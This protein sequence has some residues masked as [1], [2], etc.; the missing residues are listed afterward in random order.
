MNAAQRATGMNPL[1]A[2][3]VATATVIGGVVVSQKLAAAAGVILF[4][5]GIG[6]LASRRPAITEPFVATSAARLRDAVT[7]QEPRSQGEV[8]IDPASASTPSS[9][10]S[11]AG[12][13][14]STARF[15]FIESDG[16]PAA[17]A[18]VAL[19]DEHDV[20]QSATT[21]KD[22]SLD[23]PAR[24]GHLD[25][26][27][28]RARALPFHATLELDAG[29][30]RVELPAGKEV[31]GRVRV[32]GAAPD[33]TIG[34]VLKSDRSPLESARA[35]AAVAK[36]LGFDD[37]RWVSVRQSTGPDGGFRWNGLPDD[38][39]GSILAS[40]PYRVPGPSLREWGGDEMRLEAPTCD[41]V[42]QVERLPCLKGRVVEAS[43]RTPVAGAQISW[44]MLWSDGLNT[45]DVG[46]RTDEHG[47]FEAT[48]KES[49]FLWAELSELRD[50]NGRGLGHARFERD[51]LGPDLDV[52]DVLLERPQSRDIRFFVHDRDAHPIAG[53][54]ARVGTQSSR[55]TDEH[56]RG[57]LVAVP[58]DAKI[59]KFC[60]RDFRPARI[61]I[62]DAHTDVLDV[63]LE[64]TNEL[65]ITVIG[66]PTE[67]NA[68]VTLHLVSA[69]PLFDS[70]S[71]W[72]PDSFS[73]SFTVGNCWSGSPAQHG[74][75]GV[76]NCALDD[77]GRCVV[78]DLRPT[79]VI[80]LQLIGPMGV[81]MHVG[82]LG[83]IASTEHRRVVVH[84]EAAGR[85]L[86]GHVRSEDGQP[87]AN[88]HV[89]LRRS[90]ED[91]ASVDT[92]G[93]GRFHFWLVPEG[94]LELSASHPGWVTCDVKDVSASNAST[95]IDIRLERGHDLAIDVVDPRGRPVPDVHVRARPDARS[96]WRGGIPDRRGGYVVRDLP[97]APCTVVVD[98]SGR[99][100]ERMHD[101]REPR[102]RVELPVLGKVA[103]HW[104]HSVDTA[105]D[106]A[107]S[108]RL[109]PVAPDAEALDWQMGSVAEGAHT[110]ESVFPG[111]Y[112]ISID[113]W[114]H[115]SDDAPVVWTPIMPPQ[116]VTVVA[117]ETVR[118]DLRP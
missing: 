25:A 10:A 53:A 35:R 26:Y 96:R 98:V 59:L 64:P 70:T 2:P 92:D 34:L 105:D 40:Q 86:E 18:T 57:E 73:F 111:E 1:V 52:G 47:R 112:T 101:L 12:G 23:L 16:S 11:I 77:L 58:T 78:H 69:E 33:R 5:I 114:S 84:L 49:G 8:A 71:G 109:R 97:L 91:S 65:A 107:V 74:R 87:L 75:P 76:A 45:T 38:W 116:H 88:A 28:A 30:H 42:L 99:S 17:N 103:F 104:Q 79:A 118:V 44:L 102:L 95:P 115:A 68:D 29:T 41:L 7:T 54:L 89:S 106:R 14:A 56:G 72:V 80:T 67:S 82:S 81:V 61:E 62:G 27:I 66:I 21:D 39:S 100:F 117:D 46:A 13:N 108:V 9:R 83:S 60:A 85:G 93:S 37:Y 36:M 15:T 43:D 94:S 20:V 63:A 24:G 50:A 113:R 3:S 4:A 110:F 48:L 31:S 55:P 22:G 90:W 19:V 32:N 6:W 51:Q